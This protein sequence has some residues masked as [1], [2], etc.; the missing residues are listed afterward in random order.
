VPYAISVRD[1]ALDADIEA[2]HRY[3]AAQVLSIPPDVHTVHMTAGS[4]NSCVSVMYGLVKF[5]NNVQRLVLYIIGPDRKD[6]VDR[7]LASIERVTGLAIRSA[8]HRGRIQL[9][10][11]DLHGTKLVTYEQR[12]PAT[13]EGIVLHPTYEGKVM[14]ARRGAAFEPGEL[15]W[16]VASEPRLQ[17]MLRYLHGRQEARPPAVRLLQSGANT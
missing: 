14:Y 10:Y 7:R 16:I 11:V 15:F 3:G 8:F 4:C 17:P 1:N 9:D 5:P 13:I 12:K 6:W 2:F